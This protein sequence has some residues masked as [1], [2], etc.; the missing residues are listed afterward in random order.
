VEDGYLRLCDPNP[1][2]MADEVLKLLSDQ[3]VLVSMSKAG[4]KLREKKK[5][6]LMVKETFSLYPGVE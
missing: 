1:E 4:I 3:R 6:D 2:S 5:W